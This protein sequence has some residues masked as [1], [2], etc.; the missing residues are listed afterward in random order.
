MSAC[1]DGDCST[2][3]ECFKH[4]LRSVQFTP[5]SMPSRINAVPPKTPQNNWERGVAESR[6]GMPLLDANCE[7][8]GLKELADNRS[9]IEGQLRNLKNTAPATPTKET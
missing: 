4:K 5:S 8:V 3:K 9:T 6:P 7:P 2:G 1:V